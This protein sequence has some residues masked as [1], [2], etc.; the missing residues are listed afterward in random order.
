MVG[1]PSFSMMRDIQTLFD[2]GTAAGLSDGQ[3]LERFAGRRDATAEAAFQ[4]LVQRHGP[5][6]LRICRNALPDLNDAHDAFQATF[7]VLVR[8]CR[9][10]RKQESVGSWLYGVANR[11]A[12]RAR[13]EAARRRSAERRGGL[14]LVVTVDSPKDGD[15]DRAEFGPIVQEE[16]RRLPEKYRATIVLCYWQGLTHEQAAVQLG[17]PLGTVRSR[18][19]RAR[20]ML[21][22]RLIRRGL[23]PVGCEAAQ[24]L[25]AL[26]C[27]SPLA[28][29]NELLNSTIKAGALVATGNGVAD[30]TSASV[31]ALV[32]GVLRS[33]IM[34]KLKTIAICLLF[35]GTGV[36]GAIL[37]A[38]Q[39][40][41]KREAR[42]ARRAAR[43]DASKAQ[44]PLHALGSYV[45]EPPDLLIVEVLEALP[46]RPIS[47]ERLVRPDGTISLSFYGDISV[48]GLTVPE[49]KEKI[50]LHLR[51]FIN[52]ETLGLI[53][54]DETGEPQLDPKTNKPK[55]IDPR[56]TDRVFVDI[57]AFN[58]KNYYVQGAVAVPGRLPVTGGETILDAI[59]FAGGLLPEAD[60]AHVVLYRQ[61][62]GG[63]LKTLPI[64]IDQITMG[65]DLSTN[66]QLEPGD[67]LVIPQLA[68]TEGVASKPT[69][70][71]PLSEPSKREGVSSYFDRQPDEA[72]AP[73]H[74]HARQP[75]VGNVNRDPL[76]NVERRLS[77]VER[78][79][80][81]ILKE[82]KSRAE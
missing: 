35:I 81:M 55:L 24:A 10:I 28:I 21:R 69:S 34:T 29:P 39:S 45:V 63:S 59:N 58:S 14:R 44:P 60:H 3:L 15:P 61:E 54:L 67:R 65:D 13:V 79:L 78:K 66:Y 73:Q 74:D 18:V 8:R 32:Q 70:R 51:K 17:I 49:I 9:S 2:T 6:V 22:R 57:T 71:R 7:L 62:K 56:D 20:D 50:V 68:K 33:L 37:A 47:G 23:T 48:T 40:D 26:L 80:D 77:E 64:N 53:E 27:L 75:A 43:P 38:P 72:A 19:A 82:L 42:V 5:M 52:D 76:Y 41:S 4:A 46:G 36:V 25:D 12:A 11:V 1:G 31:A 30:V 16:V